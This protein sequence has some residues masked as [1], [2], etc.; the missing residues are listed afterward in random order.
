MQDETSLIVIGKIVGVYGI[1]GWFKILSFTRPKENIFNYGPWLVK[2]D[3]EWLEIQLQEGKPQGKGLIASLEGFTDRDEAMALVGSELAID[4]EQLPAAKEGE[5]YW[6]DLIN[7][8][9]I[10]QQNEMLGVVTEL[11]ETGAND[12]LVVEA[13]KQR[14]LIP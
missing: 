13:D 7:M 9:V 11:L 1:K 4:R 5:F 6:H 2:Q 8:Q 14:Y 10:N 3:S 12:V